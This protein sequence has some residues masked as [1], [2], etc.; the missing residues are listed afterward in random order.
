M[1]CIIKPIKFTNKQAIKRFVNYFTPETFHAVSDFR[2][3]GRMPL[4]FNYNDE[5]AIMKVVELLKSLYK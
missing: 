5:G 1:K 4:Y 2:K 3:N